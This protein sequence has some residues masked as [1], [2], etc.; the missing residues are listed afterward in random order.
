MSSIKRRCI[1]PHNASLLNE[2]GVGSCSQRRY[3]VQDRFVD[4]VLNS[5][6]I[7][8]DRKYLSELRTE[9]QVIL[10]LIISYGARDPR[11]PTTHAC[12][13]Q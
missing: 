13:S 7:K 11:A 9:L 3:R 4:V 5:P 2:H 8:D 12:V 6:L 10:L 1:N